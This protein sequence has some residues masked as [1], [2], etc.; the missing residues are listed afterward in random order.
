MVE[1]HGREFSVGATAKTGTTLYVR[2][3]IAPQPG[4]KVRLRVDPARALV[5]AAD[6]DAA[7]EPVAHP[8]LAGEAAT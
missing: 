8:A 1:Y 2:S 5:F 7:G 6:L 3:E 4:D